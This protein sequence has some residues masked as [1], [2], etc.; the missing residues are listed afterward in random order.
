MEEDSAD[1][2]AMNYSKLTALAVEGI[3]D[4]QDQISALQAENS[5]L[6]GQLTDLQAQM[7]QLAAQLEK[8]NAQKQV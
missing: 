8:I 3:K 6:K 7:A 4:Q 5:A 1:A 2:K